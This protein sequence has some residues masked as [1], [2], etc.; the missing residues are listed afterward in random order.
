MIPAPPPAAA[1]ALMRP[2][3]AR[4]NDLGRGQLGPR[5]QASLMKIA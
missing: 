4:A 1:A 3:E 5:R 2:R